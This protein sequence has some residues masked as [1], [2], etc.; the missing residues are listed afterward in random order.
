MRIVEQP[1]NEVLVRL[2]IPQESAIRAGKR[3]YGACIIAVDPV[4]LSI[5]E[6]ELLLTLYESGGARVF[7]GDMRSP[8]ITEPTLDALRATLAALAEYRAKREQERLERQARAAANFEATVADFLAREPESLVSCSYGQWVALSIPNDPRLDG[9]RAKVSAL[10]DAKEGERLAEVARKAEADRVVGEQRKAVKYSLLRNVVDSYG[11][12]NQRLRMAATDAPLGMLPE[13]EAIDL[14]DRIVFL[15]FVALPEVRRI[16]PSEVW[17]SCE[18]YD[19]RERY[20]LPKFRSGPAEDASEAEF[21]ALQKFRNLANDIPTIHADQAVSVLLREREGRW[22]CG[23]DDHPLHV[24]RRRGV[25]VE[26]RLPGNI[27]LRHEYA[28]G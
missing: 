10:A 26:V 9:L 7:P 12:D 17:D 13:E 16:T 18:E 3:Q 22:D 2:E 15:P 19:N 23:N 20:T 28:A 21:A 6:R 1:A 14:L 25:S 11:T 24:V 8:A 27:T 5:E 4:E